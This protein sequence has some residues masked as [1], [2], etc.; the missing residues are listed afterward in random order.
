MF[1]LSFTDFFLFV[2]SKGVQEQVDAIYHK[3]G[4]AA[5]SEREEKR[6]NK[7]YQLEHQK[8]SLGAASS[9]LLASCFSV[10]LLLL[11]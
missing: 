1:F 3:G 6:S 9:V 8:A 2:D 10:L 7:M 4:H 11:I 5:E